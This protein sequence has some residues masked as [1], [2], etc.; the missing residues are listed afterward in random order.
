MESGVP[1]SVHLLRERMQEAMIP[2]FSS[3]L[4]Q[5]LHSTVANCG[6]MLPAP[7]CVAILGMVRT[8]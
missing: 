3:M 7:W 2:S 8:S 1:D 4:S 5:L 6:N